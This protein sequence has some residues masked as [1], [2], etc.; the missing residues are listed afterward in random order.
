MK[1]V[2]LALVALAMAVAQAPSAMAG[3]ITG[4]AVVDGTD[5]F[6][7]TGIMFENPA[8][9]FKASLSLMPLKGLFI[10]LDNINFG[11]AVGATLFTAATAGNDWGF[12]IDSLN[13]ITN[14]PGSNG[15]LNVQGQG[16]LTDAMG[17]YSP[18]LYDY[19]LTSTT[20]DGAT[21][22]SVTMA[23]ASAVPE[24][25]SLFLL[26][27]GLLGLA[28]LLFRRAKKPNSTVAC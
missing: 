27:S 24:P 12:T 22:Y 16:T 17:G 18:T 9:V 28:G 20:V 3:S 6:N 23:P 14:N 5:T 4:H 19:T 7:L 10:N 26:G 1:R 21:G 25:A 13:V 15:F 8:I 11:S 2:A